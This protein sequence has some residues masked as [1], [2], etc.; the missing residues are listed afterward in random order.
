MKKSNKVAKIFR[1]GFGVATAVGMCLSASTAFAEYSLSIFH[2]NDFHSRFESISKYDSG[3]SAKNEAKDKCFGGIARLKSKLDERRSALDNEGQPNILAIA[4]DAFQGTLFYTKYKGRAT[5]SLFN[6]LDIDGFAL[7]NHE[8]DDGPKILAEFIDRANFTILAGNTNAS[9]DPVLMGR[10]PGVKIINKDGQKVAMIGIVTTDTAEIAAPGDK[11]SF[12]ANQKYLNQII[13]HI[14]AQGIN[15]IIV[16]SHAGY[17]EDVALAESVQGIDV[18]VGGHSNTLMSNTNPKADTPYPEMVRG[19][20]QKLVA[21]VQAYAYSKY[22]GEVKVDFDR[23]GNVTSATGDPH[24]LDSSV[25]PDPQM[26]AR[27]N[28]LAEPLNAEKNIV[29]ATTGTEI[30]GNRDNCRARE[31]QMGNL[32]TDAMLTRTAGQGIT[33]AIQ[34]GGGLRA[35]IDTGEVTKGEVLTVLPFLNTLATFKLKG[36]DIIAALENGVSRVEDG[37]GRFPQVSGLRYAWDKSVEANKGRIQ[38]VQVNED[39]KWVDIDPAKVYGVATNNYMRGGGDGYKVFSKNGMEAYDFGPGLE[40]VVTAYLQDNAPYA[41]YTDGRI[42]EGKSFDAA[43]MK[44]P[45]DATMA[46]TED[47]MVKKD[48]GEMAKAE[49]TTAKKDDGTAAKAEDTATKKDDSAVAKA[50]DT[51]AK[52]DDEAMPAMVTEYAVKAGDNLWNIAKKH[53]GDSKMWKKI[54]QANGVANVK[55]LKIGQILKLP[56]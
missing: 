5:A 19:P 55:N 32:V 34:N 48:D 18:I 1:R 16:I 12:I 28:G 36:S 27:V 21:I 46:K 30:D 45:D 23:F 11:V 53:Y 56:K 6:S 13:P 9:M 39:G 14:Q 31:C 40:D 37:A 29:V 54:E 43:V 50:E 42:I 41:A 22:L 33:I 17:T 26:L 20:S 10:L 25:K 4:G 52:K 3:C 2:F 49:D 44:K 35:S 7:G 8:F 24:L 38:Q 15:K 51:T 47:A